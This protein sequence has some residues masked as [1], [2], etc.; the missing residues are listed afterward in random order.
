MST[1]H[2]IV[3]TLNAHTALARRIGQLE[4][5]LTGMLYH[6]EDETVRS[7]MKELVDQRTPYEAVGYV[8]SDGEFEHFGNP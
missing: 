6:I 8:N 3:M 5:A 7:A 1:E 4:G 2:K